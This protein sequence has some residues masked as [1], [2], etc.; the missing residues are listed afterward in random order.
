MIGPHN[1]ELL[2]AGTV[3]V[4]VDTPRTVCRNS[5]VLLPELTCTHYKDDRLIFDTE[6]TEDRDQDQ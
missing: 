1:A 5:S 6:D 2:L 4:C 3:Q